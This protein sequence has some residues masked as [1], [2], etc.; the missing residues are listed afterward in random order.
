M[1]FYLH[2]QIRYP[3]VGATEE[4]IAIVNLHVLRMLHPTLPRSLRLIRNKRI[5][6]TLDQ[7]LD[8][9]VEVQE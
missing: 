4:H 5:V 3:P 6:P 2:A 7:L 9:Q 1:E 8:Q